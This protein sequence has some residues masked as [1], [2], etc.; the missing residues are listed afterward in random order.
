[1][2]S[3]P[4]HTDFP[5]KETAFRHAVRPD[6]F[7]TTMATVRV[8]WLIF[9]L[10]DRDLSHCSINFKP[11]VKIDRNFRHEKHEKGLRVASFVIAGKRYSTHQWQSG[12]RGFRVD[13]E[14]V[15]SCRSCQ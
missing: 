10:C 6:F 4:F 7:R 3:I 11:S 15:F 1:R 2:D 5:T 12:I 14:G 13:A 8:N 9:G